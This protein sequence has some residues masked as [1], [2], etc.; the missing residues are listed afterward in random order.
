MKWIDEGSYACG[1][2]VRKPTVWKVK[3][4]LGNRCDIIVHRL[5]GFGTAHWFL[6]CRGIDIADELLTATDLE[7]AQQEA[8]KQV[9]ERMTLLDEHFRSMEY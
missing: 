2:T 3:G 5:S 1:D 9:K 4:P 8:I 6:T 7:G